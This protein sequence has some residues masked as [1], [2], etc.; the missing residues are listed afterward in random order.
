MRKSLLLIASVALGALPATNATAQSTTRI[1]TNP[2]YGAIVTIENGVKVYRVLPGHDRVIINPGGK[3]PL[4]LGYEQV[5]V[6]ERNYNY[7]YDSGPGY[8]DAPT[9]GYGGY[10]GY[11]RGW[12]GKHRGFGRPGFK[13]RGFGPRGLMNRGGRSGLGFGRGGGGHKGGRGGGGG[14]SGGRR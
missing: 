5:T 14:H 6:D 8:Y 12:K 13:N 4:H 10:W 1:E 7:N 3:T 9:Y 2:S 11:G